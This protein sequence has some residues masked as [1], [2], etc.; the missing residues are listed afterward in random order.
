[1]AVDAQFTVLRFVYSGFLEGPRRVRA[2]STRTLV[3]AGMQLQLARARAA[4]F[5]HVEAA[6][7]KVASHD[8][9][10]LPYLSGVKEH[11]SCDAN[12]VNV[13]TA[14]LERVFFHEV[15]PSVFEAPAVP[16]A[17]QIGSLLA[18]FLRQLRYK[19]NR[20][21]PV[22]LLDYPASTYRG[23]K[24][25]LY[26]RAAEKVALR[27][28]VVADSYLS[29]FLKHEKLPSGTKRVV[30]RVIQP[31]R[32]EYNV[33]VG[34]YLH[35]LE[36]FLYRDIDAVYGRPTV[37]KGYNAFEQGAFFSR[38]WNRYHSPAALG[39]DA[40]RFD[41]HVSVPLLRWE[42][43]VYDLYYRSPELNRLLKW[44]LFN[45]GY[46]RVGDGLVKYAVRGGR[47]SGDMNTAM[48]NCLDMCA[49]VYGL[50]A[51]LGLARP[52]G[53]GVSL[54]NNGDDC[55][56]IGETADI[57]RIE[58]EVNTFFALAGFV[59]KVEP[60]VFVLEQV[61][62]CQTSPVYDGSE[63][64]MV[65]DPRASVSKDATLLSRPFAEYPRLSVQLH[66]IG[67]C[68]LALAGGLPVL[69]QYYMTMCV[70][71]SPGKGVDERFYSSGFYRLSRGLSARVRAITPEARVSF[72]RAFGVPP[73]LQVAV[74]DQ[75]ASLGPI[76]FGPVQDQAVT[77]LLLC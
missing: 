61:S 40:S 7:G 18:P 4:P 31:R 27:G 55:V 26:Q 41:Q 1:M 11:V 36:H 38:E 12:L 30:P 56:I 73:D 21:T 48:G 63:W 69:Q 62:F 9:Y 29:T 20:L 50:L 49:L 46:V 39:L 45:R 72:A 3:S 24:L 54:F 25:A 60:V 58:L 23:R 32:P 44:Q 8:L 43:A 33:V 34:R 52:S 19:V 14:L 53:T 51:K 6:C 71:G 66:A 16:T 67:Q 77:T 15:R 65:R 2:I 10:V 13:Q 76:V 59:M 64:R 70:S 28:P 68:G 22:P 5:L 74:E 17:G 75:L 47:C 35:Q 57:R 42:H 37:M